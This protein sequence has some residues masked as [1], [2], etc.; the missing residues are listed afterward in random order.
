[1]SPLLRW[2]IRDLQDFFVDCVPHQSALGLQV[3]ECLDG[4]LSV[5][6]P[7]ADYLTDSRASE[8]LHE[9]GIISLIDASAGSVLLTQRKELRRTATLDLRIDFLRRCRPGEGVSCQAKSLKVSRNVGVT[10]A[11]VHDSDED[12]P[13]AVATGTFAIF[14]GEAEPHRFGE[15][16]TRFRNDAKSASRIDNSISDNPY[17]QMMGIRPDDDSERSDGCMTFREHLI[18]N[19]YVPAIHGGAVASL[20]HATA[21]LVLMRETSATMPPKMLSCSLEYLGSPLT[22]NTFAS[23]S[24]S[25]IS[26]R[27]ANVRVIAFQES[28]DHPIAAA[29]IQFLLVT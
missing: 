24:I 13:I 10:H 16:D 27:F 25:S 15:G 6:M 26:R 7:F 9:G 1:M 3:T 5:D 17:E 18:G 12:S 29:T 11:K 2:P 19:P 14:Q 4:H 28:P 23:A 20:L 21:K 22:R 8:I